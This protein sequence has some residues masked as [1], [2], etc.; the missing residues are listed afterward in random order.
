MPYKTGT[1]GPQAKLRAK[2]L[3]RNPY[4]KIYNKNRDKIKVNARMAVYRSVKKG[5]T[6]KQPCEKCYSKKVQAHHEDYS[7]PLEVIWLCH[8]HHR[9]ADNKIRK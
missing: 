8:K 9:D 1:W 6:I 4:F 7:K 3:K 2:N 5:I